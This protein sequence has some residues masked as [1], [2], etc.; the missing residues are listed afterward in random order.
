MFD[1]ALVRRTQEC[2]YYQVEAEAKK[3]PLT[4]PA[5]LEKYHL[6]QELNKSKTKV[7]NLIKEM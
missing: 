5:N 4:P 7:N 1:Q 2:D 3:G 6:H